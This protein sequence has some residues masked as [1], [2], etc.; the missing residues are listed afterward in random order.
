MHVGDSYERDVVGARAAGLRTA[1]LVGAQPA[2]VES[3]TPDLTLRS[4]DELLAYLDVF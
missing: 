4:L 1:W 2:P 3:P